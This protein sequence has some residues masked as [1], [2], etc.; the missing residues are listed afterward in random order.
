MQLFQDY[1]LIL[2]LKCIIWAFLQLSTDQA[3]Y[4]IL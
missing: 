4:N 1:M 2:E 3:L